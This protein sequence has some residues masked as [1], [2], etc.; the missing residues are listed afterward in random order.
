[1][2]LTD[3]NLSL[4]SINNWNLQWI[5]N[6]KWW[7]IYPSFCVQINGQINFGGA[8]ISENWKNISGQWSLKFPEKLV[9]HVTSRSASPSHNVIIQGHLATVSIT[10]VIKHTVKQNIRNFQKCHQNLHQIVRKN[11]IRQFVHKEKKYIINGSH[12]TVK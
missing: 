5:Q 9:T 12:T 11:W 10:L 8:N 1:M 6:H 7:I 3:E 4:I 2:H